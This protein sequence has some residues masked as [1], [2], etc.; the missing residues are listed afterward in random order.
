MRK[1]AILLTACL[2]LA[3]VMLTG[4]VKVVRIGEEAALINVEKNAGL[5]V[6]S[7]WDSQ[8]IPEIEASAIELSTLLNDAN[9]DLSTQA[10]KAH[11]TQGSNGMDFAVHGKGEVI[12]VVTDKK[13]GYV[14]LKVLGY[15]GDIAVRL[16][17]GTVFKQYSVRDYLSFINVNSFSDQ[18]EYAQLSKN[19]NAYILEHVIANM[20]VDGLAGKTIEFYGCFTYD[21]DDVILITP[22]SLSME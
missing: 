12:E 10:D 14:E 1:V 4:C 3:A 15:E 17:V 16:Q 20:D 13:A 8:A 5:D 19:I 6:A 11:I 7:F 9:G 21:K 2:V 18:I 22:V